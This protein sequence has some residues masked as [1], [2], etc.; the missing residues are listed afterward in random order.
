MTKVSRYKLWNQ[1]TMT[2]LY[3]KLFAFAPVLRGEKEKKIIRTDHEPVTQSVQL[4]Y[5]RATA[6]TQVVLFLDT[7]FPRS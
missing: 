3:S 5:I 1:E 2:L 4:P 7:P 6:F